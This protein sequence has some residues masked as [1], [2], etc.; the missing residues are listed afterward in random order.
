[1]K[2]LTPTLDLNRLGDCD[3]TIE[4]VLRTWRSRR[5]FSNCS[6]WSRS[7]NSI[8]ASKTSYL[9]IDEMA[10]CTSRPDLVIG[11]DFFSPANAMRL[12]EVVRGDATTRR[13]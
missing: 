7:P 8:M 9:D 6:I 1:M 5:A 10:D 4:A 3:L 12:T 2:L 11:M 13:W